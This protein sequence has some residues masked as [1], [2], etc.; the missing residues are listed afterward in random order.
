MDVTWESVTLRRNKTF[1]SDDPFYIHQMKKAGT[2]VT[3]RKRMLPPE[4]YTFAAEQGYLGAPYDHFFNFFD[5][6][7]N[8]REVVQD[9]VF[10]YRAAA[11]ALLCNDSYY[12]NKPVFWNPDKMQLEMEEKQKTKGR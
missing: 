7:R 11:P 12:K 4:E 10:G 9:A 3:G 6:V 1:A 5:A 8:G 2:P